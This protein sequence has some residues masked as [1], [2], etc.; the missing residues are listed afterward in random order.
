MVDTVIK[1]E[2]GDGNNIANRQNILTKEVLKI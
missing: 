1:F 2:R